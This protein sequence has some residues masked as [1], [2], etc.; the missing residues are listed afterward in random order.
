MSL[1]S[2]YLTALRASIWD[3][4]RSGLRQVDI[5]AKLG[6]SRQA[7]NQ[8]LQEA[9]Q[10]ITKGLIE[11]A[12]ICKIEVESVD[13]TNGILIGW[14]REFSVKT[15][16]TLSKADGMQVWYEHAADCLH[17]NRYSA[18]RAYLFKSAKERSITL[19]KEQRKLVPSKLAQSLFG[20]GMS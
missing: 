16:I 5:A 2:A 13:P 17:C 1:S 15:L 11:Q 18:C 4:R 8:A 19:T 14:S 6:I 9:T 20:M 12:T 3:L 7:V 10:R